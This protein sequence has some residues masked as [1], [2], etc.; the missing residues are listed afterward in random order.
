MSFNCWYWYLL[1]NLIFIIDVRGNYVV[2]TL[3]SMMQKK[4]KQIWERAWELVKY[5]DMREIDIK[6]SETVETSE[7][8]S[9]LVPICHAY[10]FP[11]SC[12]VKIWQVGIIVERV[13]KLFRRN[14]SHP[15]WLV[16]YCNIHKRRKG[17]F[18][19]LL[20]SS[21]RNMIPDQAMSLKAM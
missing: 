15:M 14:R 18:T 13:R 21:K 8:C 10:W 16:H 11:F 5:I 17:N 20:L 1:L 6:I 4:F 19:R 3:W 7:S 9:E 2:M 12:H